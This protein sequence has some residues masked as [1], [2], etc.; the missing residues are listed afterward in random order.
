MPPESTGE[1]TQDAMIE[2]RPP[3]HFQLRQPA[4]PLAPTI[5]IPTTPPTMACVV[6]TGTFAKVASSRKKV[7]PMRAAS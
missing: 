6:E 4:P 7:A 1:M 5:V 3:F 2:V